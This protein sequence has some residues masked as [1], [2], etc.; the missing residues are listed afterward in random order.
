MSKV[1]FKGEEFLLL[2][3]FPSVGDKAH[4]FTLVGADLSDISLSQF[5]G[6]K[7][8]LNIFPSIDTDVCATSVR[9]F[10]QLASQTANVLCV[11]A[12]LPFAAHRFCAAEGITNVTTASFFRAY[13]FRVNYGV[14]LTGILAGLA[15]RAVV[16]INGSGT[17]IYSELVAEI[18][19]E[20]NYDAAL[21]ALNNG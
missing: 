14:E 16:V 9:K 2:G 5:A 17:V 10:N 15:A 1:S 21:N 3:A 19:D 12:D 4:D 18:T 11:S 6:Q 8:L 13:D 20:P 7:L